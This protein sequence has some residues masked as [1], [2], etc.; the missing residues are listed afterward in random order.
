MGAKA[1]QPAPNRRLHP[2]G[3]IDRSIVHD[4]RVEKRGA[5]GPAGSTSKPTP[6]SPPPPKK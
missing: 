6:S 3:R 2:D 1:P 5:N 4:D